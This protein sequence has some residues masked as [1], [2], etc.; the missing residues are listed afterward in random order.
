MAKSLAV[1]NTAVNLTK[2]PFAP[3]REAVAINFT[4]GN[5]VL[6]GSDDGTTY[7]TLAT[8][9]ATGLIDASPLPKYVKCSTAATIYLIGGA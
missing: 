8:V 2:T 6:Q 3:G 1:T 7:T 5:L 4:A 9:P